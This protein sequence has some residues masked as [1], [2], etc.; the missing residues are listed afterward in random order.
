MRVR[1][2]SCICITVAPQQNQDCG[3]LLLPLSVCWLD[4]WERH[5]KLSAVIAAYQSGRGLKAISKALRVNHSTVRKITQE[6]L[7]I[8]SGLSMPKRSSRSDHVKLM[9]VVKSKI[10][11]QDYQG[12]TVPEVQSKSFRNKV[13]RYGGIANDSSFFQ[14]ENTDLQ[15]YTWSQ[16][17]EH[18]PLDIGKEQQHKSSIIML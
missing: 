14:K 1:S 7:L 3:S 13:C 16:G 10:L 4:S 17:L 8:L 15:S 2:N 5:Q 12:F 18:H 6:F 9:A 11:V